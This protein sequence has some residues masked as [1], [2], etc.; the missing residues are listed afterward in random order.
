MP[1]SQKH[2]PKGL[3]IITTHVNADFDALASMLA[4][5][6]L[7][8]EALVVFPG[9]QEKNLKNFFINSMAYLFNMADIGDIDFAEVR[10]LVL[11]DTRQPGRIGKLAK[12]LKRK[13]IDIHIYDHHPATDK[14][15]KGDIAVHRLSG[16]NVTLLIE[17]IAQ[18]KIG[19]SADEATI[20][21]LGIY[22]DTGSFTFPST[23]EQ[24][25]KAAAFLLSK[26][27]NLNVVSDLIARELSPEQVSLLNDL[28]QSATRYDV[29]GIEVVVTS[30]TTEKYMPDFAFLVQKMVKMENLDVLFAIGRMENKIYVVARSRIGDVD[31]GN[32]VTPLGGGGHAY[33]ASASI[34]GKTLAQV[35]N[36]LVELL[37]SKI[38]A[39]RLAANL[40]T[41]PAI[42]VRNDVSCKEANDLLT[43]YNI[44]ALLVTE[45]RNAKKKLCGYITRQVIE[46]ALYHK[47]ENVPVREYMTTE[48]AT[49]GPEADLSEVQEK[50]IENKQRVLPVI[51]NAGITGVITRTDLLN[52]LVRQSKKDPGDF[53][54]PLK[55]PAHARTR[56]VVKFLKE[57]LPRRLLNMLKR[58]GEVAD[59]FGYGAYV[60]GG[61]VRDLFLYRSDEDVDIVI[62]GDGI[63]F[64][65]KYA[66][67]E[68]AR[69][70]TYKKFG[71]AVIIFPDGY[72]IDVASARLEY[73]KFPA[74]LPIV[75][76]SSIKLDL[77]RRDFTIN[78][79]AIQLNSKKFGTL[80]D[81]FSA[82]KDIKEKIIRVL[83]NLSFVEDPTRVFRAIRFEQRFGFTIGKLTNKL[84]ENAVNMN[85]LQGL[86]GR[87]VL[88]ELKQILEEDHPVPTIIRLNDFDL[89]KFIDP[90]IQFDK[91]LIF[92]LNSVKQA[93]AWHDLLFLDESY[94]KWIVYFLVLIHTCDPQC[95]KEICNRFELAPRYRKIFCA[96]RFAA[97]KCVLELAR[98]LPIPNSR[99]YRKLSEFRTELILYMMAISKQ[100]KIKKAISHYFTNLRR[101]NVSLQGRDLKKMGVAPGP[102]YRE[103]LQ[104][105]LDTKLN[106]K[107]KTRKDELD[108][109]RKY[110]Q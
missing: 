78:T 99:L 23:T 86:S 97:E 44:N 11:V 40:M 72:K 69:I 15:I 4:A 74:A 87:R 59:E 94:M 30:V 64:A 85:F 60:V 19:I 89:L 75:E 32:I 5:Q 71:T 49:V 54:D 36:N 77:F 95:S 27:A 76:M 42:T 73:Y 17:I 26:G 106:G 16:A 91:Q 37:Y 6:K 22:E 88:G 57:R 52:I 38:E 41:S 7:Y 104:T 102:I 1:K 48:L 58:I 61:F 39:H 14:D 35:E 110:A 70:H 55:E 12:L 101:V 9:S 47:L 84:I 21:C 29:N 18:K 83:H 10:R 93:L 56:N 109:A 96:E 66:K 20:M 51:D 3:T 79:L 53:P 68:G 100:E 63:A 2:G 43:R 108:F 33:A 107:L 98:S 80:I 24:D 103:I 31:V 65:K 45:M 13:D 8:P 105:A 81:F 92:I 25:F 28:I 34:K 82:R 46:K 62:E 50:I 67:L 90:S